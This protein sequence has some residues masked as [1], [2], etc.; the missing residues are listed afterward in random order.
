LIRLLKV[1]RPNLEAVAIDTSPTML[2]SAREH[3]ANDPSVKIVNHD[4]SLQLPDLGYFDALVSSFAIN[5]LDHK[6]QTTV[7]FL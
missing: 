2:K 7:Y 1:D 5:H 3:F 6:R 4:L